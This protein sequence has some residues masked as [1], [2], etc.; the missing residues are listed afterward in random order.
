MN[1]INKLKYLGMAYFLLDIIFQVLLLCGI[2]F[3]G[4]IIPYSFHNFL[5]IYCFLYGIFSESRIVLWLALIGLL[6]IFFFVILFW[7]KFLRNRK[8]FLIPLC[9]T[10]GGVLIQIYLLTAQETGYA[11]LV[12]HIIGCIIYTFLVYVE[13]GKKKSVESGKS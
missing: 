12:F 7:V 1:K 3:N 11:G 6:I 2:N 5:V 13:Y 9:L 4:I 8:C 10:G